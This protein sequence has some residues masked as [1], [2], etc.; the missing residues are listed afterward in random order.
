MRSGLPSCGND[1]L[2]ALRQT[3]VGDIS[4]DALHIGRVSLGAGR[5]VVESSTQG[6]IFGE[7]PLAEPTSKSPRTDFCRGSFIHNSRQRRFEVSVCRLGGAG[8]FVTNGQMNYPQ[9]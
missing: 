1:H 3:A 9:S 4:K 8:T 7:R 2:E 6:V 5:T